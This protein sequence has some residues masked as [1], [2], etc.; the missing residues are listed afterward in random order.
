VRTTENLSL[1]LDPEVVRLARRT[2]EERRQTLREFFE[3]ALRRQVTAVTSPEERAN[4]LTTVED[5]F[6]QRLDKRL[7]DVLERVAALSAKEA[8]DQA[9]TLQILKRVLFLQIDDQKKTHIVIDQ[10]WKEAVERVR[11]RGRP[12]PPEA[13]KELEDKLAASERL[14]V[15]QAEQLEQARLQTERVNQE[16]K[17]VRSQTGDQDDTVRRLRERV[18]ELERL[19]KREAWV[20]EQL[21]AGPGFGR[22]KTAN[23][24]RQEYIRQQWEEDD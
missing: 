5:A 6:L 22:R 17:R 23:E 14:V 7:H 21:Q 20:C 18:S 1:R 24:L 19:L 8:T 4:L 10:A 13:V 15:E 12:F 11:S 9:H 3:D 16:L 2:A